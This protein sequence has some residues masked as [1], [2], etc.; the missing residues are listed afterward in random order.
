MNVISLIPKLLQ[1]GERVGVLPVEMKNSELIRLL[2]VPAVSS[3]I[4]ESRPVY[5]MTT[6]GGRG[7]LEVLSLF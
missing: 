3:R 6:L 4:W 7:A 1:Y 5:R 2:H